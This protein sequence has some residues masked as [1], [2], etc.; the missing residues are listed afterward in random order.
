MEGTT[1]EV[2]PGRDVEEAAPD[3]PTELP[4]SA[5]GGVLKRT[6]KEFNGD[7]LTDLA[8]ALTYY[9]V[10]AIFPMLIV[11]VSVLGLIGHSVT[12]PLINN[13]SA[14][15]PG[16][17]KQIFTSAI[18][19]IESQ[20]ST[21]GLAFIVGL[22]LALWSASGYVAAFM[23]ASNVVWDV[24]EG[25]P[26]YKTLPIRVGVTLVTVVLLTLSA[27]AVVFTGSLASKV[28][29]LIGVGSTAVQIWD[30]AKWPVLLV[31]ITVIL[32]ILYYT[33]PNVRQPGFR[34]VT[35]GGIFAVLMWIIVSAL[36]AFYV[37]N[38]SSYNKTYG[39]MASVIVFLIW[40]WLTNV[41][42]LFGAELNAEIERGR[43]IEGGHPADREPYLPVRNEPKT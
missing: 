35:P 2:G 42:I 1:R 40:L 26:I 34:W 17:A 24:G 15:A 7:H 18:H 30:I 38:F 33:G 25:R 43:Q 3:Q 19:N 28:G 11:I 23:R 27:V 16:T 5:W 4:R 21:A 36:F 22:V 12:Q 6:F 14:V 32:A 31:F 13:L 10:L 8:A 37:A 9:G 20:Q 39:A 41:V 29:N